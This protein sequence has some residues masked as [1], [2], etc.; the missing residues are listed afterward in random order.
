MRK[1]LASILLALPLIMSSCNKET[2]VNI[3]KAPQSKNNEVTTPKRQPQPPK[4]PV[5][6]YGPPPSY[7]EDDKSCQNKFGE[8]WYCNNGHCQDKAKEDK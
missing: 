7:C 8:N 6:V 3:P 5:C 1:F 2:K 4:E